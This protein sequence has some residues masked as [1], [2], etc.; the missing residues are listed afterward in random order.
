MGEGGTSAELEVPPSEGARSERISVSQAWEMQLHAGLPT[1]ILRPPDRRHP[2]FPARGT[3]WASIQA[4]LRLDLDDPWWHHNADARTNLF[5]PGCPG[6]ILAGGTM[7]GHGMA[8]LPGTAPLFLSKPPTEYSFKTLV[9][10]GGC[11]YPTISG[12]R[13]PAILVKATG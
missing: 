2:D 13:S 12:F 6:G 5:Q 10:G 11:P 9:S 8:V 1:V 3:R 7:N 4:E